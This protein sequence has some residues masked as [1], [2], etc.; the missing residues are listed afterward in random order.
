LT[1]ETQEPILK[2]N[3]R[4]AYFGMGTSYDTIEVEPSRRDPW[5][6][7]TPVMFLTFIEGVLGYKQVYENVDTWD[8]KR[9][10]PFS[11]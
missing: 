3:L 11:K 9:D 1:T 8:F 5:Y 6:P 2:V 7:V 10:T 4:E